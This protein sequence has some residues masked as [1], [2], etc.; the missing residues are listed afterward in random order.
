MCGDHLWLCGRSVSDH[1]VIHRQL[2]SNERNF[3]ALLDRG[4]T[5]N[6]VPIGIAL[7]QKRD[8]AFGASALTRCP[9]AF[10]AAGHRIEALRAFHERGIFT[11]V[12]LEPTL[13][14]EASIDIIKKTHNFVDLYKVG[15]ANYLKKITKTTD[16]QDYT[17]RTIDVLNHFNAKH[18]IKKDLQSYLPPGYDNP[19]RV[20]QH[21]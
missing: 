12:S 2:L 17:L 10:V 4:P 5:R 1:F 18:Y 19:L 15:R 9:F 3:L 11:W 13:D 6:F 7:A 8:P 16:W 21:H 20:P 14:V